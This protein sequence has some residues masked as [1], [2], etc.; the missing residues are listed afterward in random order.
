MHNSRLDV[1]G[2][3]LAASSEG[4]PPEASSHGLR[5]GHLHLEAIYLD[6]SG[7]FTEESLGLELQLAWPN[8]RFLAWDGYHHH[9]AYND[10]NRRKSPLEPAAERVGLVEI[11][12]VGDRDQALIDP[13][14]IIFKVTTTAPKA[15][16]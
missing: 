13:N 9:L 11:G 5:L 12:L 16:A 1:D 15:T 10:W 3:R 8:A 6:P 4:I 7:R 14:G 2:L